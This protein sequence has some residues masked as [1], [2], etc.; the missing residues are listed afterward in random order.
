MD[1]SPANQGASVPAVNADGRFVAY[2]SPSTNLV[3]QTTNGITEV[4]VYDTQAAQTVLASSASDGTPAG[5]SV[6]SNNLPPA[7]SADG[8][9]VSFASNATNLIPGAIDYN[10]DERV[11]LKDLT[12]QTISLVDTDAN[13]MPLAVGG[14]R[15]QISADGRFVA[16]MLYGQVFLRDMDSNQSVA[17]SLAAN[18][19][20]GNN[21]SY[22]DAPNINPSGTVV[23]FD[24]TATNLIANDTNNASDVFVGQNPLIGTPYVQSLTLSPSPAPGGSTVT[25]TVTLS[26]AATTNGATVVVSINNTATQ[27][28]SF[29]LVPAGATRAAFSFNTSL[30]ATET[31]MTVIGS[32]NGASAVALLTLEPAPTLSVAP[33]SGDF[34]NQPVGTTSA[35]NVFTVAN[36]GTAP[37]TLNS[38][39]IASG[40]VFHMTANSCGATLAV[41]ANCSV[42]VVFSPTTAGPTA[43]ILQISYSSPPVVESVPL[44]GIG[45]TPLVS[46]APAAVNFGSQPMPSATPATVTLTNVGT[47]ALTNIAVSITGANATDFSVSSNGCSGTV[48]PA[49]SGCLITVAFSPQATGLRSA[50]LSVNDNA[51]GSPQTVGLSGTGI[52]PLTVSPKTLSYGNQGIS[53]TSTAKKVTLTNNTGAVVTISSMAISGTDPDDFT[54]SATTCGKTLALQKSCT[55]SVTFTPAALGARSAMFTLTDSAVN[56]PQT[57]ALSGTGV[58]QVTLS[59]ATFAFGNQADGSTSAPK[60]VT[61]TNNTNSALPISSAITGTN[62]GEFAVSSNGCGSSIGGHS[63]CKMSITFAPVTPGAKTA[64]LTNTDSAN[65]SPQSVSL[66]G[67]GIAPVS[68][69]PSSLTFAA[70]KVG[71]TSP[72][73]KITVKNNL[74]TKLT[75]SGITLTGANAGDFAQSATTCGTMLAAG[76]NCTVSIT[77]TPAAKGSRVAELDVADSAITSPQA[78]ALTGTGK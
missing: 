1:G 23:A 8:R 6:F 24:S 70:Q 3:S 71:T 30:V 35:S 9:F 57:V 19:T 42:S 31:V 27:V 28:P 75:F 63:S 51:V 34:G 38:E 77:F 58:L 46:L 48:L 64:A 47:A 53:S 54:Q 76:A 44:T 18:G 43:D 62:A 2:F 7:M 36:T 74:K 73:K 49:N 17:I 29:V 4:Y 68:V 13:A 14:N 41:G 55:I 56:S 52:V 65:N 11:F 72:E 20:P 61:L 32:Y 40:Q 10:G 78:V 39:S 45:T 69:T 50:S 60:T 12:S 33:P 66:T 67:T 37:L 16:Y 25:G 22:S 15:S 5:Q 59:T 26:G 21:S